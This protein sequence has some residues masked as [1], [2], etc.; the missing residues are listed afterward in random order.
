MKILN[1][2]NK[3]D[4]S[5]PPWWLIISGLIVLFAVIVAVAFVARWVGL[6]NNDIN[7]NNPTTDE[8]IGICELREEKPF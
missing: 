7:C 1:W 3:I 8:E 2:L 6:G 4:D 5:N